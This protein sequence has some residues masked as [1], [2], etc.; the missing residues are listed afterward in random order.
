[1]PELPDVELYRQCLDATALHQR[2]ARIHVGS[3]RILAETTP[4]GLGRILKGAMFEATARHGKYLFAALDRS[5]WLLLHFGMTGRLEHLEQQQNAPDYTQCLVTFTNGFGL[6]Y[7][8]RRKLGR[9]GVVASPQSFCRDHDIGPDALELRAERFI[10]LASNRRGNVKAWLMDQG[11]I[12][13]IGNV[14]SDEILFQAGIHPRR[15]LSHMDN[16]QLKRLHEALRLTL[17]A[18]I[19]ANADPAQMP[20]SFLL[21]HRED[22]G[23]CPRCR[24]A[25]ASVQVAGRTAWYC[26]RC[27]T[28]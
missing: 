13:G 15:T 12:A 25:V 7:V 21:P 17:N 3:P 1:M 8:A 22:G 16:E 5:G 14:Y 26:P 11:A 24:T 20:A 2:I 10:E 23:H 4:Q 6:A 28:R 9:I 27:Q 18:A 19:E